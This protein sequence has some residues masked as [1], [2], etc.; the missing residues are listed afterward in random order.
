MAGYWVRRLD[1]IPTIAPEEPHDP[2]WHPL[3]YHFGVEA[4]GANVYT[5]PRPDMQLVGEHDE[6]ASGQEELYVVLAGAARFHLAGEAFDAPAISVVAVT[7]PAVR[8]GALATEAGTRLLAVGGRPTGA[9]G[10]SWDARH[11][12]GVPRVDG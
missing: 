9:F 7:D 3:T 10:S 4:F 2:D 12:A 11:F 5:A 8:R 6:S 1:A